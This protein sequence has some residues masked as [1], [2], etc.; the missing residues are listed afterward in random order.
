MEKS[1]IVQR[2]ITNSFEIDEIEKFHELMNNFRSEQRFCFNHNFPVEYKYEY[3]GNSFG[4]P[5]ELVLNGCCEEAIEKEIEF[6]KAKLEENKW[7]KNPS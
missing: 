6:I 2:R 7:G 4:V 5:F 1:K 3:T